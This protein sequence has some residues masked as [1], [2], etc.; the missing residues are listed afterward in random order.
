MST[1][2]E[3]LRKAVGEIKHRAETEASKQA[4]TSTKVTSSASNPLK[5]AT[6]GSLQQPKRQSQ[7]DA[8][9]EQIRSAYSALDTETKKRYSGLVQQA[10][11]SS[12]KTYSDDYNL[13]LGQYKRESSYT[14]YRSADS[15]RMFNQ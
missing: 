4:T 7:N 6:F 9:L 13:L 5:K 15:A 2:G 1:F 12:A 14:G 8:G 3:S 11:G 10:L